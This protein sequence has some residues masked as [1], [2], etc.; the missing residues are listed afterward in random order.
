MRLRLT[1]KNFNYTA[2]I[3]NKLSQL[4]DIEQA[5]TQG[6][7]FKDYRDNDEIKFSGNVFIRVGDYLVETKPCYAVKETTLHSC[8]DSVKYPS[9]TK[10]VKDAHYWSWESSLHFNIEDYGKTWALTREELE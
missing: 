8:Y 1:K 3:L 7:Y 2:P 10:E 4:E 6:F 9:E 5:L